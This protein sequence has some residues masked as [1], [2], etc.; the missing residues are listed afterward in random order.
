[1]QA[2]RKVT[3]LKLMVANLILVPIA[4]FMGWYFYSGLKESLEEVHTQI[5]D[6]QVSLQEIREQS[7]LKDAPPTDIDEIET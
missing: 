4:L 7:P 6:V 3:L 2:I 5:F 1:M